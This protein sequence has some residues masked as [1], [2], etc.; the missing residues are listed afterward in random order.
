[1]S[2]VGRTIVTT[3]GTAVALSVT[4]RVGMIV[5]QALSTNT[6]NVAVGPVS[7]VNA[8]AG[9]EAGTILAAGEVYSIPYPEPHSPIAR[10]S[11]ATVFVN[12]ETGNDG[13]DGV[14]W[15]VYE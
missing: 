4:A 7:T 15:T 13:I 2:A 11:L 3:G 6:G 14:S 1:M 8:D 12:A 10:P 5:V 9:D